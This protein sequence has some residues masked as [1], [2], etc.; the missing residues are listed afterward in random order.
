MN[1]SFLFTR[2]PIAKSRRFHDKEF[3][4]EDY[5]QSP[6]KE[7]IDIVLRRKVDAV[8]TVDRPSG[9][10]DT[11]DEDASDESGSWEKFDDKA[12]EE[13]EV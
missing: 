5:S 8:A 9:S 6:E 3:S 2:S 13:P 12:K 11:P 10:L 4:S 1:S 7:E